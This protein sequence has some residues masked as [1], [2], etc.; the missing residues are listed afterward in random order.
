MR[1]VQMFLSSA[2]VSLL[3]LQADFVFAVEKPGYQVG[4]VPASQLPKDQRGQ[5]LRFADLQGRVVIV[6]FWATWCPPCLKELPVLEKMQRA[7]PVDELEVIAISID[8]E[9]R[10]LNRVMARAD[11]LQMSILHDARKRLA[12]AFAV[13]AVPHLILIDHEG[14]I[15]AIHKGYSEERLDEYIDEVNALLAKRAMAK[16]NS[17]T[18]SIEGP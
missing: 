1:D 11:D 10:D 5:V 6:S 7:V 18:D 9:R 8:S 15:A 4:D 2:L 13:T 16:S 3:L 12:K 17:A 14:R